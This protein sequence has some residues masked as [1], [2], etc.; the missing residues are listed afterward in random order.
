M[1]EKKNE[2][3]LYIVFPPLEISNHSVAI[4]LLDHTVTFHS[5]PPPTKKSKCGERFV[6]CYSFSIISKRSV[7]RCT[8]RKMGL[9]CSSWLSQCY[10]NITKVT[11]SS[12]LPINETIYLMTTKSTDS[13][14]VEIFQT[15][16]VIFPLGF[17]C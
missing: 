3:R 2:R 15:N 8:Y 16:I 9:S 14:N 5:K 4:A 12:D 17:P 10:V 6:G 1:Q 11:P 13:K 7:K